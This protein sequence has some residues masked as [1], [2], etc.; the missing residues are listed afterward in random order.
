MILQSS[1]I[2]G[3]NETEY[4]NSSSTGLLLI[5]IGGLYRT[6]CY[7]EFTQPDNRINAIAVACR[8][9]GYSGYESN[10]TGGTSLLYI[11]PLSLI[12]S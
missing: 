11:K 6:I 3:G 9:V 7:D 1:C 5:C 12:T 4:C 2:V 8:E 10:V